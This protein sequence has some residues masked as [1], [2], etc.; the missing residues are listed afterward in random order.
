MPFPKPE[1]RFKS[2]SN[3]RWN[4]Y[5]QCPQRAMFKHLDK[6]PEPKSEPMERGIFI[7]KQ[8]EAYFKGEA[9]NVPPDIHPNLKPLFREIKKKPGLIVEE[10]WGFNVKWE[11]VDYFDWDNCWLRV[12]VDVGWYGKAVLSLRD[13]KTGKF[14]QEDQQGGKY[15]EQL[16]LYS[17]AGIVMYPEATKIE[18]GLIYTDLGIQYP[19]GAPTVVTPGEAKKLQAAWSKKVAPM[20]ADRRFSPRPGNYCRWCHYRKSNGGP[21]KF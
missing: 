10:N 4:D 11:Q 2:W 1:K 9:R 20:F 3:S 18:T 8:E 5:A 12:K 14:R 17:A 15:D 16:Q 19:Q 7:A 21:C 6:L 13:N